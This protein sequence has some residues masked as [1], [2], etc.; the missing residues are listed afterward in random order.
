[1][2]RS[3]SLLSELRFWN[4]L[5]LGVEHHSGFVAMC[6]GLGVIAMGGHLDLGT[7]ESMYKLVDDSTAALRK[8]E[9]MSAA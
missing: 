8:L 3:H 2:A 1:M 7:E 5:N 6:V 4:E 9:K